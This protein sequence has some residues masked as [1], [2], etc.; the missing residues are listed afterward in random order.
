M[1]PVYLLE[2]RLRGRKGFENFVDPLDQRES[3]SSLK[4]TWN[5]RRFGRLLLRSE[6]LVLCLKQLVS[7]GVFVSIIRLVGTSRR[8]LSCCCCA[9][10]C[11]IA[12][13]WMKRTG[14]LIVIKASSIII[15]IKATVLGSCLACMLLWSQNCDLVKIV[16]FIRW[17]SFSFMWD[18]EEE[19]P[20]GFFPLIGYSVCLLR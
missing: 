4:W 3:S 20:C 12:S 7:D 17:W 5:W 9:F 6:G 18:K 13:L 2:Q 1:V 16:T 14:S 8:S 19:E 10:F 11:A 15:S